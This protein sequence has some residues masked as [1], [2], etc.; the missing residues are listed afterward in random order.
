MYVPSLVVTTINTYPACIF[1]FFFVAFYLVFFWRW[2]L[3]LRL[4]ESRRILRRREPLGVD[5]RFHRI[6]WVNRSQKTFPQFRLW[7]A[8]A[9][10]YARSSRKK[11]SMYSKSFL[12][13]YI[14][15]WK[16][17]DEIFLYPRAQNPNIK[18][19][20]LNSQITV[21]LDHPFRELLEHRSQFL[22][23]FSKNF[24]N[25]A[26]SAKFCQISKISAR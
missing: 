26:K 24:A 22:W 11:V 6:Y 13:L 17:K 25:V 3:I 23:K 9:I 2:I 7:K 14:T 19:W 16:K 21:L 5:T 20:N 1:A 15:F 8:R 12:T 10:S 18:P 4:L